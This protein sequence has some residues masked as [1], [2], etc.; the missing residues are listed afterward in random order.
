[1]A[2]DRGG[3][4][5]TGS[6]PTDLVDYLQAFEAGGY[7]GQ[8]VVPVS[9]CFVCK[10]N[11]GFRLRVD[12]EVGYA[13]R[14]CA[15]CGSRVVMLDSADF[16]EDAT[17]EEAACPCGGEIF[18]VAVGFALREDGDVRWVSIG[19]RCRRDGVLGCFGDWNID[20]SPTDQLRTSV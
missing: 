18:D 13:D 15:S 6:S 9:D 8:D 3:Q 4:W 16:A 14:S 1:M 17:P 2:I 7:A 19:L 10:E 5:W 20:Y 12:D 11:E